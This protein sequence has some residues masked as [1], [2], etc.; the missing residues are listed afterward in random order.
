MGRPIFIGC[1]GVV[2]AIDT[3]TGRDVWRRSLSGS[4]FSATASADVNLF[5]HD[6]RV[7]AGS[8]G[9]VFCLSGYDGTIQ[10]HNG[11]DGFGHNDVSLCVVGG[12]LVVG[13]NGNVA[14]LDL[15]SGAVRWK[16]AITGGLLAATHGHD[17]TLLEAGGTVFA[18]CAGK[19][20][21]FRPEDGKTLWE[22]ELN[23]LGY[24]D[25]TLTIEGRGVQ[26]LTTVER[27]SS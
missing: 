24:D 11:L 17:V 18:G 22:N 7:Y 3:D 1:N 14:S 6:R 2:A 19:L 27:R 26:F 10:W 13:C 16:G 15:L 20:I 23:G 8:Q 12:A 4:L 25:V 5:E 21:R 9:H